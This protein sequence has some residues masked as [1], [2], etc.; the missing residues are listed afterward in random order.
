MCELTRGKSRCARATFDANQGEEIREDGAKVVYVKTNSENRIRALSG[1]SGNDSFLFNQS[2]VRLHYVP[3]AMTL[4][5]ISQPALLIF[6]IL[7]GSSRS[8]DSR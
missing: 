7:R 6:D 2:F 3:C 5:D 4:Y 8:P 1:A